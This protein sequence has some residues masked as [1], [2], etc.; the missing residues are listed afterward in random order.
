MIRGER[1]LRAK[2][3][4]RRPVN[5][6]RAALA[7]L[8][9]L[10]A[11]L[12]LPAIAS[13]AIPQI[14]NATAGT[15]TGPQRWLET[16]TV[17]GEAPG[18]DA[19]R[20]V[21][22]S[23]LVKHDV[24][25]SITG[26]KI[27]Q[28]YNATDNAAAATTVAATSQQPTIINGYDYS[29]VIYSYQTSVTGTGINPSTSNCGTFGSG[30]T[31]A[32]A[33]RPLRVVAVDSSGQLSTSTTSNINF[34]DSSNCGSLI[35]S[36]DYPYLYETSQTATDIN[37]GQ[38][39]TFTYK[40]DDPD[41]VGTGNVTFTGVSWRL[42]RLSDGATTAEQTS[43]LGGDNTA[44]NLTVNFPSRG[45][46]VV[47]AALLDSDS[48]LS[49]NC[50]SK[51]QPNFFW[52]LGAVDVNSPATT[53]PN[54]SLSAT[55]PQV[56]GNSTVS[57]TFDDATDTAQGGAPQDLEWDRN[58]DSDF[59][60]TTGTN[61][62]TAA[63]GDWA[64]GLTSP[65]TTTVNTTG[66]TPGLKTVCGRIGDNGALAGT[67]PIRRTKSACTQYLVDSLPVGAAQTLNVESDATVPVTLTG[68]DVDNDTLA[69]T[70]PATTAHGVVTGSGANRVYNP[71]NNFAG[72]DSFNYT[73]SDG[74]GGTDTKT[75]TFKVTPATNIDAAPDTTVD[76]LASRQASVEYSSTVDGTGGVAAA[77]F[78][79]ALDD[80][81]FTTC[82]S[83]AGDGSVT[84]SDLSDGHHDVTVRATAAGNGGGPY[85]DPTPTTTGFEIDAYPTL[86]I[87]QDPDSESSST[88]ATIEFTATEAGTSSPPV[89]TCKL[90]S[91]ERRPCESPMT[92]TDLSSGEHTIT[93][94]AVDSLGKEVSQSRT[95]T[96]DANA[97]VTVIDSAP[98]A[99][100]NSADAE[101][102]FSSPSADIDHFECDVDGGG[103]STCTSPL[104][105]VGLGEGQHTVLV[106]AVDT[107]G[108]TDPTPASATWT[109]DQTAPTT[110]VSSAPAG[111]VKTAP[112]FVL[113]SSEAGSTFSCKVDSGGFAA[114]TSPFTPSGSLAD[115]AHTIEVYATDAAGNDDPAP[116]TRT[117]TIDTAPP[118][119][120]ITSGPTAGSTINSTSAT[121]GFS[122][123]DGVTFSCK[124]DSGDFA[125]C[126]TAS[127][128]HVAG[129]GDGSHTFSVRAT[130]SA[131]NDSTAASRTFTVDTTAPE[132]D[133]DNGP[134]GT[135]KVASVSFDF[136]SP[137][138]DIEGYECK[139]DSGS[140]AAC[141][142]PKPYTG[143]SNGAHTFT[144]R[145]V[146]H[147]L[148]VDPTPA[149]RTF[150]VDTSAVPPANPEDPEVPV[151]PTPPV[152]PQ[153][154]TFASTQANCG[155]P[156]L[157]SKVKASSKPGRA[158]ITLTADG[159][160]SA[161]TSTVF[162]LPKSVTVGPF[163]AGKS[164]YC[165]DVKA[166]ASQNTQSLRLTVPKKHPA[167]GAI[168][169]SSPDSSMKFVLRGRTIS[170]TTPAGKGVTALTLRLPGKSTGMFTTKKA[171]T[172]LA[173]K[174]KFRDTAGGSAG[175]TARSDVPCPKGGAK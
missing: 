147:A 119:V 169:L 75:I 44:Q 172:T 54:I 53:S 107:L 156:S 40:G 102:A 34:Q 39:V 112:E 135:V 108:N 150:T 92:Y 83:T 51:P 93:V 19:S 166:V 104:S 69:F 103:Y 33:N 74:F 43:C 23:L 77:T 158:T 128:D 170:A 14:V 38:S 145:A 161:L 28:D 110:S 72:T 136:S 131:G 5:A 56:N 94:W 17:S 133:I 79:C 153:P 47:E 64:T 22:L 144:V 113:S 115:G 58:G 160:G 140:Y 137:A 126:D 13:A 95:F 90:D 151:E 41:S 141:T 81:P 18:P 111:P 80:G 118:A 157:I 52:R 55:R 1:G 154:C 60:D 148:N 88:S 46:W 91:G 9:A 152:Q 109:V 68:T 4:V 132:T 164:G 124:V 127:S 65:Q 29:R 63:L 122:S 146:D 6:T 7:G 143:L 105:L 62:D 159:G 48:I 171:C 2:S 101:V 130:D 50:N 162:K 106:R 82:P 123:A 71:D 31:A 73:V 117:F 142:A 173:F 15:P 155:T 11:V 67:D 139:L 70:A 35:N 8:I 78:E 163:P 114:C 165:C 3:A 57:A 37:P 27:D 99:Q 10:V 61:P 49:S 167:K 30:R 175:A 89:T 121:F 86:T 42:R 116:V 168:T 20:T 174:A 12:A 149:T 36:E 32:A 129:L 21:R 96:V 120:S 87:A 76:P 66:M 97:P 24:G 26:L 85:V 98:P 59:V 84:Y 45:R 134:S 25:K 125:P 100:T 138:S 16:T